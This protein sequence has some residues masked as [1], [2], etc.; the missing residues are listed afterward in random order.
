M[1][2]TNYQIYVLL[3]WLHLTFRGT[4]ATFKGS[5]IQHICLRTTLYIHVITVA[6]QSDK[7]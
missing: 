4:V 3:C 1:N 6:E 2:Q 7:Q 5:F